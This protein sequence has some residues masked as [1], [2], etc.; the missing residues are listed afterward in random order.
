MDILGG[1]KEEWWEQSLNPDSI[2]FKLDFDG[3]NLTL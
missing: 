2:I 3:T 1:S